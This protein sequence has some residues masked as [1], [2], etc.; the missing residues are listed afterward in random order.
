MSTLASRIARHQWMALVGYLV[1]LVGLVGRV[2]IDDGHRTPWAATTAGGWLMVIWAAWRVGLQRDLMTDTVED[3]RVVDFRRRAYTYG[4]GALMGCLALYIVADF[5]DGRKPLI[6]AMRLAEMSL[7]IGYG[8]AI[9]R[10]IYLNRQVE[11][12]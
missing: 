3:E 9:G 1:V 12:S 2:A 7:A 6:S 4:F 10:F 11:E 8:T 5:L